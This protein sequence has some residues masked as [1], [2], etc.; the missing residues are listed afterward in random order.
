MGSATQAPH[1]AGAAYKPGFALLHDPL[2]NRD[3]AFKANSRAH[4]GLRGLVPPAVESLE[5]QVARVIKQLRVKHTDL[6]RYIYLSSLLGHNAT[7]FYRT[8]QDHLAEL[9]PIIYTP[10]VGQACQEYG[11]LFRATQGMYFSL[12]DRDYFDEICNNWPFSPEI[13]VV[14]DG[15]RIL[16]LGDLGAGGLGIPIGKLQL[17][18]AGGGFYPQACLPIQLDVGTDNKELLEDPHYLGL[19]YSRL[20]G[21][22]HQDFVDE[23]MEAV[24]RKWPG[25]IVQFEDF[26]TEYALRYLDRYRGKYRM[27]NDDVQGTAAVVTAGFINGMKAQGTELKDARV[28]MF[29]AGSSSVGVTGYL[30]EA[31]K[32]AGATYEQA[33]N[34]IWVCDSKGLITMERPGARELNEWKL[35]YARTDGTH[36]MGSLE[37]VIESVKPHAL[38]GLSGAGPVFTQQAIETM[39]ANVSRPLIFPLSNPTQKAEVTFEHA[40]QWTKGSLLFAAGSP[41][42]DVEYGGKTFKASQSNNMYVFP[43]LGKGVALSRATTITDGMI[44]AGAREVASLVSDEELAAGK[45][46]P[47]IKCLQTVGKAVAAAVWREA[48]SEGVA[49]VPCPLDVENAVERSFYKPRYHS[50]MS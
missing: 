28:V 41:F 23:F 34:N 49:R 14:T 27:F 25:V 29:G 16:G 44:L 43:G 1:G 4:F 12:A 5:Q 35:M 37:E 46:Y 26:Q 50:D 36:P 7:L 20:H 22:A 9:L 13:I 11:R 6:E 24:F 39:A 47:D 30:I 18:S 2:N 19:K 31:M 8:L 48:G 21:Q 45:I 10:T 17:Y 40:I 3:T 32:A 38:F 42:A 15:G 33:R